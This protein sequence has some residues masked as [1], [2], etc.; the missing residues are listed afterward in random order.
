MKVKIYPNGTGYV[1]KSED[2]QE[3]EEFLELR[4]QTKNEI[5][6]SI[7][8]RST[9]TPIGLDIYQTEQLAEALNEG[10]DFQ[11]NA[12]SIYG[13]TVL[14]LTVTHEKEDIVFMIRYRNMLVGHA[15]TYGEVD[16]LVDALKTAIQ[17]TAQPA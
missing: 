11:T 5:D 16:D 8:S 12:T 2:S 10:K 14:T 7:I 3:R 15:I 9:H 6:L 1:W 4:R 13:T 17:I